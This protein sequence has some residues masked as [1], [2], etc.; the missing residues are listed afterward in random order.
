MTASYNH[1][2]DV[3]RQELHVCENGKVEDEERSVLT[4]SHSHN[5]KSSPS[6]VFFGTLL[7]ALMIYTVVKM[8]SVGVTAF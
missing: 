6:R 1:D 3:E 4:L 2:D 5:P 8:L 7:L